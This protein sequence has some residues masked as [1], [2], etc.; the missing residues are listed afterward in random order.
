[1]AFKIYE[2][3]SDIISKNLQRYHICVID[4]YAG[5]GVAEGVLKEVSTLF[6]SS[7]HSF[8]DEGLKDRLKMRSDYTYWL[9]GK[10]HSISH[11]KVLKRSI[12]T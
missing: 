9:G 11:M 1:M 2:H 10:E 5:C 12:N 8:E 4:K 3:L 7:R 6:R